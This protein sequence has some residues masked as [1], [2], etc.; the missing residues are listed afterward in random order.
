MCGR[1][2][3]RTVSH[4][5]SDYAAS[6][7]APFIE[8]T[9]RYNV[10]PTQ[11]MPI[12]RRSR[13]G[14]GFELVPMKWGLVPSWA[15]DKKVGNSLINARAETIAEKPTFRAAFA[16][17]RC[18][19][20]VDGFYEWEHVRPDDG[21]G[22][23]IPHFIHLKNDEPFVFAGLWEFW[24]GPDRPLESYTIV[25]TSPNSL[26]E[27]MHNRM[28]VMLTREQAERWTD[29]DAPAEELKS[30]LAP[31]DAGLMDEYVVDRTVNSPRN[32]SPDLIVPA[33][34]SP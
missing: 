28:P 26:M 19:V 9:P 2:T 6:L 27:R 32:E 30:L 11:M 24:R 14:S 33:Q 4:V 29:P 17:R 20:P 21:P 31:F 10:A 5:V 8:F 22:P 7:T 34:T 16:K 13:E 25:T 1:Y 23:K 12:V 18:L 3:L 15:K